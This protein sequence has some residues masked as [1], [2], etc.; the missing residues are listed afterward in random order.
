[1]GT[2]YLKKETDEFGRYQGV[3]FHVN[4]EKGQVVVDDCSNTPAR[5]SIEEAREEY[6][7]YLGWGYVPCDSRGKEI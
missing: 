6:R 7:R 3:T 2:Y 1:M 5:C 4:E